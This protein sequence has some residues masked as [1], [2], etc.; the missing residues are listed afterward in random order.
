MMGTNVNGHKQRQGGPPPAPSPHQIRQTLAE[1]GDFTGLL[2]EVL[3]AGPGEADLSGAYAQ[4]RG[5]VEVASRGDPAA[6][7]DGLF[8][9]A[10]S[11]SGYVLVRMQHAC[12]RVLEP[13]YAAP[14]DRPS[15]P[16]DFADELLPQLRQAL[17][18]VAELAQGWAATTRLWELARRGREKA[19]PDAARRRRAGS[20]RKRRPGP[21]PWDDGDD[22]LLGRFNGSPN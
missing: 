3:R 4:L 10:L 21:T 11:L 14:R 18:Q 2:E 13:G 6:F 22:P 16:R 12:V 17:A 1:E 5:A 9:Q 19:E 7:C 15:L 20:R 8:R